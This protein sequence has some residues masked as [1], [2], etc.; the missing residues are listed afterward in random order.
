MPCTQQIVFSP[1]TPIPAVSF[2]HHQ[3]LPLL[4]FSLFPLPKGQVF[5]L[6]LC[7]L[8]PLMSCPA[9]APSPSPVS[10]EPP[11]AAMPPRLPSFSPFC[12]ARASS[13]R[14]RDQTRLQERRWGPPVSSGAL[15]PGAEGVGSPHYTRTYL[16][17]SQFIPPPAAVSVEKCQDSPR[18]SEPHRRWEPSR[19]GRAGRSWG[20]GQAQCL[21]PTPRCRERGAHEWALPRAGFT[22]LCSR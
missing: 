19:P 12:H 2:L 3:L 1:R 9:L 17:Q 14:D 10:P 18:G 22:P 4:P 13:A 8:P 21:H 20:S 11:G 6:S 16:Q 7:S 5:S 15:C